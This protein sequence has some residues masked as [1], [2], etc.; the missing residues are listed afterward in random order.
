MK[1]I[2]KDELKTLI[3]RIINECINEVAPEG[4]EGTVK[5]MKKHKEIDNPWALAHWMKGKGMKSHIKEEEEKDPSSPPSP[6]TPPAPDGPPEGPPEPE[7]DEEF[8]YDEE[9]EIKLI[10]GLAM[11]ILKLLKMHNDDPSDDDEP[12][13]MPASEEP[14]AAPEGGEGEEEQLNESLTPRKKALAKRFKKGIEEVLACFDANEILREAGAAYKV[15]DGR[16]QMERPG[17]IDRAKE[18]QD[19]PNVTE[20]IF[21]E[22]LDDF[23]VS[24]IQAAA[25]QIARQKF[26]L[27]YG[28]LEKG[29][30]KQVQ[31]AVLTK[32]GQLMQ[33]VLS[34]IKVDESNVA[35]VQHRSFKTINDVP[36]NP[37]NQIDPE[38]PVP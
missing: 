16:T 6:P 36:Q 17:Q 37:E 10:K 38:V 31:K 11:I 26:G 2:K 24:A 22:N 33:S 35:H 27:H 32:Q 5:G 14:P 29:Q 13:D 8:G 20:G 15:H 1:H 18:M 4:W 3:K 34:N 28:E 12:T 23:M 21:P 30:Q 7:G 19:N 25:D 9:E